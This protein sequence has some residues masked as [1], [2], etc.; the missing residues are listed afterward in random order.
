MVNNFR[1]FPLN[2]NAVDRLTSQVCNDWR[3]G[4]WNGKSNNEICF[5]VE[6]LK[7]YKIYKIYNKPIM[8]KL[9]VSNFRRFGFSI[10]LVLRPIKSDTGDDEK[11]TN[12]K[13]PT[14]SF[15]AV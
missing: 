4:T 11:Q 15:H 7:I 10:S 1:P 6:N 3:A 8:F 14:I 9:T 2:I 13:G 12:K 5:L